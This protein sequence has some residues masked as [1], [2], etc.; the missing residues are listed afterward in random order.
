MN[1]KLADVLAAHGYRIEHDEA[2]RTFATI[3]CV[4][5]NR[6]GFGAT[7]RAHVAAMLAP[8]IREAQ[9]EAWQD[10][11]HSGVYNGDNHMLKGFVPY[12]NPYKEES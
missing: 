2:G 8:V 12:T 3:V 4:C 9:A 5:G 11:H 7:H 1:D 6:Y 10:G